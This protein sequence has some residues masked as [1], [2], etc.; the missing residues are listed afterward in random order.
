[1]KDEKG[2][3]TTVAL[4]GGQQYQLESP[5]TLLGFTSFIDFSITKNVLSIFLAVIILFMIFFSV[6]RYYTGDTSKAPRGI[7]GFIEP[8]MVFLR[9]DV[10]KPSIGHVGSVIILICARCSFSFWC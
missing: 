6:M 9:D 8:I 5:S 2:V 7:A 10:V 3:E 1:V 4:S